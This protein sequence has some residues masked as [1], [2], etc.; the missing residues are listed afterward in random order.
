MRVA[1]EWCTSFQNFEAE[2][3]RPRHNVP[4][5]PM[6]LHRPVKKAV[7]WKRGRGEYTRN[8]WYFEGLLASADSGVEVIRVSRLRIAQALGFPVVPDV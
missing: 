5:L 1:P 4:P 8:G 7:P 6:A 3:F 2:N